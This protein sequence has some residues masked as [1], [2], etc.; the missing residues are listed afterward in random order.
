MPATWVT[1]PSGYTLINVYLILKQAMIIKPPLE[2]NEVLRKVTMGD[3]RAFKI[4]YDHYRKLV[5]SRALYLLKSEM[6]AEEV[7]QEVMLKLWKTAYRLTEDSNLAAYL[8]TLTRNRSFTLLKRKALEA[9]TD[10]ELGKGWTEQDNGT[11]EE[12]LLSDTQKVLSDGIALLPLQQK[13][14]YEL[15]HVEGMKYEEAAQ[16]MNLSVETVRSYMKLALRF[17]RAHLK[18]HTDIVSLWIIFKL[19]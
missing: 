3:E 14:V 5:Y 13:L 1:Q 6:L 17:L 8:T 10:T 19:F 4:L 2:E 15:C 12:I 9:K 18:S 16:K 7:L 11:E